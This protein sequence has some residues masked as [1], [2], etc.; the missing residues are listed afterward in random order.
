MRAPRLVRAFILFAA[1]ATLALA[2]LAQASAAPAETTNYRNCSPDVDGNTICFTI[3]DVEKFRG[4]VGTF[5]GGTNPPTLISG[6]NKDY[7]YDTRLKYLSP[8]YFLSPTQS[9][10]VRLSYAE[11]KPTETP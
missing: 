5:N 8:P 2:S 9:A 7:A 3:H 1:L 6:Y 11:L 10:W 4:P